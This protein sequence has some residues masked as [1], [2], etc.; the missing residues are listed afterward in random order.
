MA[1][2][3]CNLR[4]R[5]PGEMKVCVPCV[6]NR[7]DSAS[8][9]RSVLFFFLFSFLGCRRPDR[10]W[11]VWCFAAHSPVSWNTVAPLSETASNCACVHVCVQYVSARVLPAPAC[12]C[13]RV[14][15]HCATQRRYRRERFSRH[16]ECTPAWIDFKA[17]PRTHTR[18]CTPTRAV[19]MRP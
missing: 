4:E 10:S 17:A 6:F 8:L 3:L 1:I 2:I 19:W 13:V 14:R 11:Q 7:T 15:F 18:R 16:A 12:L 5:Q 9:V